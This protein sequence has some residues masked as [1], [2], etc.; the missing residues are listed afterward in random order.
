[1]DSRLR[2]NDDPRELPFAGHSREGGNPVSNQILIQ[3]KNHMKSF[4]FIKQHRFHSLQTRCHEPIHV[5]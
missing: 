1:M 4:L 3:L 2:G 5:K